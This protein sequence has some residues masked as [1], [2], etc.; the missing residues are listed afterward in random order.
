MA[1]PRHITD[2]RIAL[3]GERRASTQAR[4]ARHHTD[5]LIDRAIA[6]GV[7]YDEI[8]R[9][10]LK[11]RLSKGPTAQERTREANR[12]RQRRWKFVT[13]GNGNVPDKSLN[14][15]M[16]SIGS[17]VKEDPMSRLIRKTTT[18]EEFDADDGKPEAECADEVEA[19][20]GDEDDD[21]EEEEAEDEEEDED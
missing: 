10:A 13:G 5:K 14:M 17:S 9:E 4:V 16:S 15:P 7:T 11:M 12:L 18:V 21:E 3:E 2:L 19:A 8:A 6:S 20:A 1:D